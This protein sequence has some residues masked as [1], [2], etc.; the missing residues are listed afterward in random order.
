MGRQS[1]I[2]SFLCL[3]HP[4]QTAESCSRNPMLCPCPLSC[5]L[6]KASQLAQLLFTLLPLLESPPRL[7]SYQPTEA[8]A[9]TRFLPSP[10]ELLPTSWLQCYICG[11]L[12]S[13]PFLPLHLF[14][15]VHLKD[16]IFS[17]HSLTDLPRATSSPANSIC[18]KCPI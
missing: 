8:S 6:I 4:H 5:V 14:P 15:V 12:G 11:R 17:Q 3:K 10:A 1:S 2:V 18:G 16:S 13:P 7:C 9:T